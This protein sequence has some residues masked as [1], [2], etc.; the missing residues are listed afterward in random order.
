MLKLRGVPKNSKKYFYARQ[1]TKYG[2]KIRMKQSRIWT[3]ATALYPNS[4][5]VA[6][7][8][9]KRTVCCNIISSERKKITLLH[10][11]F[12]D[13]DSITAVQKH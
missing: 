2:Y 9:F 13:K 12:I 10:S 6:F 8:L 3:R 5:G 4:I 11:V 1:D 7:V